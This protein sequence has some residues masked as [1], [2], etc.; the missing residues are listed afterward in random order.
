MRKN[1]FRG[2]DYNIYE[3]MK[4]HNNKNNSYLISNTVL[5]CDAIINLPKLKTHKLAGFTGSLK[6][7]VGILG[8]KECF[9]HFSI[10]SP[11]EFGD[12]YPNPS[13]RKRVITKSILDNDII[14][15]SRAIINSFIRL[16]IRISN[17]IK[18]YKD[19]ILIGNWFGNDTVWRGI[20]DLNRIVLFSD[21]T[22]NILNNKSRKYLSI[23]DAIISGE[24]EG[25]LIPSRKG[26]GFLISGINPVSVDLVCS[27]LAGFDYLKI[28]T[29][30][31]AIE[32]IWLKSFEN[33]DEIKLS[34]NIS[35]NISFEDL[36]NLTVPLIPS[37]GWQNIRNCL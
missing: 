35:T 6:N 18:P 15:T 30:H 34:T 29:I 24:K 25:P 16:S 7:L 31:N 26:M 3:V 8:Q 21:K 4:Y 5:N 27:V 2:L 13:L 33:T 36:S 12:Q 10:G 17:K 22:G 23:V 28:P 14:S 32:D 9:P 37:A 19:Y 20:I 11:Q 1:K